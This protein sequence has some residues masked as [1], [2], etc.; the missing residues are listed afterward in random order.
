MMAGLSSSGLWGTKS[1]SRLLL[2]VSSSVL[3]FLI[4][5][6][7]IS[8]SSGSATNASASSKLAV[9]WA[10]F[11]FKEMISLKM[12]ARLFLAGKSGSL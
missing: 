2:A 10:I 7:A 11:L 3:I 12:L 6:L 5:S 8:P 4:S 1:S 9:S